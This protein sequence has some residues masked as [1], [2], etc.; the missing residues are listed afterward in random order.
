MDEILNR[1]DDSRR[2]V[3]RK[4]IGGVAFAAPL[5]ASFSLE[6]LSVAPAEASYCFGAN[7]TETSDCCGKAACIVE[8]IDE[9]LSALVVFLDSSSVPAARKASLIKAIGKATEFLNAGILEGE[10]SCDSTKA[11][12]KFQYARGW[13]ENYLNTLESVGLGGSDPALTGEEIIADIDELLACSALL[14][15]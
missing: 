11:K 8:E 5:M 13:M 9:A 6:G 2:D 4:L 10:G 3:L 12:A 14:P 7:Q 15:V 1:V